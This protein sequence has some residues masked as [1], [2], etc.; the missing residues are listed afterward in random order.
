MSG[1]SA[2]SG[3]PVSQ[4]IVY[5]NGRFVSEV[6]ARVPIYDSALVMGDMAYEVTRTFHQRP[7]RLRDHI[8]RLQHTLDVLRIDIGMPLDELERVTLETLARNLPTEASDVDWNIIHN[9]SRGPA[10]AFAEAFAPEE[11]RPTLIV[12]CYPIMHRLAAMADAFESGVDLVIPPQRAIPRELLD[13]TIKT[14]SR[15]HFQQANMQAAD[16]QP[17]AQAVLVDPDGFLTEG[18]SSNVFLV[19]HGELFT[20]Q[21]RHVLSGVT[22][23]LVIELAGRIGLVIHEADL[24]IDDARGAD[25]IFVTSTSIGALHARTFDGLTIN[26]GRLGPVTLRMRQ[27]IESEVGVDF[28]AQSKRY[29]DRLR[30][31]QKRQ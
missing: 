25:E 1:P 28:A 2:M 15:W 22:R 24:T 20:P 5:F 10:G 13:P 23:G 4:R 27:A 17:G 9:V 21:H 18:T 14:R 26:G 19:S 31:Q 12:S 11:R 16:I 30:L 3:A 7:F 29:A 6:E 8:E